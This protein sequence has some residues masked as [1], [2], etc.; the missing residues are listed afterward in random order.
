MSTIQLRLALLLALLLAATIAGGSGG[1]ARLES[2]AIHEDYVPD[3]KTVI[4]I[5]KAV[6]R[7]QVGNEALSRILPFEA[8]L[9]GEVWRVTS[10]LGLGGKAKGQIWDGERM[11]SRGVTMDIKRNTGEIV[12][13]GYY[14]FD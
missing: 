2:Q 5:A 10:R 7:G 6:S 8:V 14:P 12:F 3:E 9:D 1:L 13:Y 4:A 11:D